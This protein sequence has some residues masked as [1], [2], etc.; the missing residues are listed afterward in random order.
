M[1]FRRPIV[2][3]LLPG[4]LALFALHTAA[5]QTP[6]GG[7][8]LARIGHI[9]VIFEENRS[10]DNIFGR[11]PGANGLDN[12]GPAGR[13]VGLDGVPY[14]FLPPVMNASVEPPVVDTR[15]PAQLPNAPFQIDPF[16]PQ[17]VA[18]GDL[19]HRFYQEQAQI[20]GG[21]MDKFAA[22][23][24]AGGLA[25][26]Y[27]DFSN[28]AHWRLAKEFALADNIFH[29]AFGGSML[30]HSFFVCVCAFAWPNAPEAVVAQLDA[31]G[32]MIRDGQVSPEG[33][34]I[35]TS[36]SIFLHA[37]SDTDP[38]RLVPAQTTP[39]I[40]DRLDAAGIS[41]RWYSGGYNDAVAGRQGPRF[42]YHHQPLAFFADLAPGT[43]G[44]QAHLGDL[45]DL[46]AAIAA[47]TLPQVVF[48]KP[49]AKMNL[50]P[51]YTDLTDGDQHL[52]DL[53]ARLQKTSAYKDMLIIVTYDEN[54]GFWDHV[55]PP[56]RDRWGPGTRVPLIAIGTRVKRG[57]VDHTSYDLAAVLKTIE[58]RFGLAPLNEI[59]RNATNLA[60]LLQ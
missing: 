9:V 22:V 48:Y 54:G 32:Q 30:S 45:E 60:A 35:N 56:K 27:Y 29:T 40:G 37:P 3:L 31:G 47:D 39:H 53:V 21:R 5:A 20:D 11:F 19:V 17:G 57:Y 44:Q 50:H 55:A 10:F 4:A 23:S 43:P 14:D 46:D 33:L 26:G 8:A 28:S 38:S 6:G 16:V 18:T 36:R 24:N 13:Q 1:L 49:I 7:A 2:A 34:V 51:G 58:D 42:E 41:W 59:D 25:M 52:A 12:A 15:F